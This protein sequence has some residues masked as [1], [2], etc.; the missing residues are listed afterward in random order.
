[1]VL[2]ADM[3]DAAEAYALGLVT[4]IKPAEDIDAFVDDL[5]GRLA[6]GPPF[7]LA[8]SKALLNDGANSSLREALANEARAQPG[9]F[10]T[11]DSGAAYAA[12]AAKRDPEFTGA[13]ALYPT[14]AQIDEEQS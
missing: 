6:A 3:I 2:L 1:L 5:A 7:A 14:S 8:Q 13:W 10:A 4:W 9:N 11:E 12:F